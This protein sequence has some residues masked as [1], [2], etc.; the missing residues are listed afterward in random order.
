MADA[1]AV[2]NS[3]KNYYELSKVVFKGKDI[4]ISSKIAL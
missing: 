2:Y 1:T 4:R 3:S